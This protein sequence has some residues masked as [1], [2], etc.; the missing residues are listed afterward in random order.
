MWLFLTGTIIF[1][2]VIYM[3]QY[4]LTQTFQLILH[5]LQHTNVSRRFLIQDNLLFVFIAFC[6]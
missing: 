5:Q 2:S 6:T 1:T 3:F 4:K